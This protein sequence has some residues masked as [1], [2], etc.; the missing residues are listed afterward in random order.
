MPDSARWGAPF[1]FYPVN[2]D[3]HEEAHT[4]PQECSPWATLKWIGP[5]LKLQRDSHR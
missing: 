2:A 3:T 5:H 4:G 1:G